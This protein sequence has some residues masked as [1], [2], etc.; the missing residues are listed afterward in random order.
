MESGNDDRRGADA[1]RHVVGTPMKAGRKIE[2][3]EQELQTLA[4]MVAFCLAGLSLVKNEVED[5]HANAWLLTGQKILEK[6]Y[7]VPHLAKLMEV[8]TNPN[9]PFFK[10]E[11]AD[12]CFFSSVLDELREVFFWDELVARFADQCLLRSIGVDKYEELSDDE[13]QK[14]TSAMEAALWNEV[15]EHGLDRLSF[16]LPPEES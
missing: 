8:H 16:L 5:V 6:A 15:M 1:T 7:E 12:N 2:F 14:R 13:R 10:D 4:E 3:S 11:Y 9:F